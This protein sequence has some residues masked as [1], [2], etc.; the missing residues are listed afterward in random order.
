MIDVIEKNLESLQAL[1][2]K[3]KVRNLEIFGSGARADPFDSE[4][5]DLDFLV[6]FLPLKRGEHAECYFGLL[7][8]L[9]SLFGLHVDLVMLTAVK[10]PYFLQAIESDREVLYAA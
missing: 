10:N 7:E 2:M 1:C 8:G 6:E 4:T 3:N 9:E 5:S